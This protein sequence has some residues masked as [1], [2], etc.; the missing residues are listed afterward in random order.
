MNALR[1]VSL[2]FIAGLLSACGTVPRDSVWTG[3]YFPSVA[4]VPST[5]APATMHVGSMPFYVGTMGGSSTP[6]VY[7]QPNQQPVAMAPVF[8]GML[9]DTAREYLDK[10]NAMDPKPCS[11]GDHVKRTTI[12]TFIGLLL[13]QTM[14]GNTQATLWGGLIGAL[15]GNANAQMS[16]DRWSNLRLQFQLVIDQ[17]NRCTGEVRRVNGQTTSDERCTYARRYMPQHQPPQIVGR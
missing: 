16:C 11:S 10:L 5:Q 14:G 2:V 15:G 6:T 12:G 8:Q 7:G 9:P 13:G 3:S 4:Y 1:F 17:Q